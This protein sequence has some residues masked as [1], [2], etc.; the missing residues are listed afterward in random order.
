MV[1]LQ[2]RLV[3]IWQRWETQP[4][5]SHWTRI[6]REV[7]VLSTVW[8]PVL[9]H[10]PRASPLGSVTYLQLMWY[11]E[12][13]FLVGYSISLFFCLITQDGVCRFR[14]LRSAGKWVMKCIKFIQLSLQSSTSVSSVERFVLKTISKHTTE[15]PR[16]ICCRVKTITLSQQAHWDFSKKTFKLNT[17]Y[18][19]VSP[20]ADLPLQVKVGFPKPS[21]L[22][23]GALVALLVPLR[24]PLTCSFV[25][26]DIWMKTRLFLK[27]TSLRRMKISV[28]SKQNTN[29]Q[30]QGEPS[31]NFPSA[32]FKSLHPSPP[33]SPK[34]LSILHLGGQGQILTSNL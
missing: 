9:W 30:T 33:L 27:A 22:L 2:E 12:W 24:F 13:T 5:K 10:W 28:F 23:R 15:S 3:G 20:P 31:H 21:S 17:A 11:P 25:I 4:C 8:S 26:R 19:Q 18:G 16:V 7:R 29:S 32:S 6:W 1:F 34:T 14:Y